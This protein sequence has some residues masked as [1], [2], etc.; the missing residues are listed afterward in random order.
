LAVLTSENQTAAIIY[1]VSTA[2]TIL[3]FW[4]CSKLLIN[5]V[6]KL[7]PK[8]FWLRY[9]LANLGRP[10]A[11]TTATV[12]SLGI[13]MTFLI[14]VSLIDANIQRSILEIRPQN[15]PT[16]FL[17]DIQPDQQEGVQTL[18]ESLNAEALS[19]A[20]MVR[21][22]IEKLN[23]RPVSEADIALEVRWAVRGDRG[24]SDATTQPIGTEI[25][26]GEWWPKDY[27]GPPLVSF[28]QR[29]AKGM[30]LTIGD[31]I[32]YN[33]MGEVITAEIR[34]LRIVDYQN[35]RMNFSV[36]LSPSVLNAFPRSYI[37]TASLPPDSDLLQEL[38]DNFPNVSPIAVDRAVAQVAELTNNLALAIRITAIFTVLAALTVL[39]GALVANE[40]RRM[41]DIMVLKVLGT[42]RFDIFRSFLSEYAGIATIAGVISIIA[43]TAISWYVV[44]NFRFFRF[45]L[46]PQVSITIALLAL[47]II[48]GIGVMIIL[49]S[50][51]RSG[52]H[53]LR[54]E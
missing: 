7:K 52:T 21:G 14:S 16:H 42:S 17:I 10:G 32:T 30:G 54:N 27:T 34:S 20:P 43:G 5:R 49:R 46:T 22:N 50:Y 3:I 24:I 9:G 11:R 29:L 18:L 23:G 47:L 41:Y 15:A 6:A 37:A 36:I 51:N 12:M 33:I 40:E 31:T 28:D 35:F 48:I 13:G 44:D 26:A 2:L 53:Y 4:L 38:G 45:Q 8:R 25:V 1:L 19:M 39:I